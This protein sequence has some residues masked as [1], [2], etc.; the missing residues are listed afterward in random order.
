MVPDMGPEAGL[1][2]APQVAVGQK[3]QHHHRQRRHELGVRR[4][5]VA[6]FYCREQHCL[7]NDAQ[8]ERDSNELGDQPR[9]SAETVPQPSFNLF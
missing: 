6:G 5:Y 2:V 7:T 4:V 8:R 9:I 1:L 3:G